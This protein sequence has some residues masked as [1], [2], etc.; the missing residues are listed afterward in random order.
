M[1]YLE[2]ED[3][4]YYGEQE[5]VTTE[6]IFSQYMREVEEGREQEAYEDIVGIQE[7]EQEFAYSFQQMVSSG[8]SGGSSSAVFVGRRRI[9]SDEERFEKEV[10]EILE[11]E[12]S[13]TRPGPR[14]KTKIVE[15]LEELLPE[16]R[17]YNV[18]IF[19]RAYLFVQKNGKDFTPEQ[20]RSSLKAY[21]KTKKQMIAEDFL[22]YCLIVVDHM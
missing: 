2:E 15:K 7:Q 11:E 4:A 22:R 10:K 12:E 3:F 17:F 14:D 9:I 6:D 1:D 8:K 5:N 16:S 18:R 21:K 19:T 20:F 13:V